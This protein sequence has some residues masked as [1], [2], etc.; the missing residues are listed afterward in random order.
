VRCG[1]VIA[2]T[3]TGDSGNVKIEQVGTDC[4]I[5]ME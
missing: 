1:N 2:V 5:V 3:L 4:E